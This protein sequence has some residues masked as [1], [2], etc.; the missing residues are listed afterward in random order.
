MVPERTADL[1]DIRDRV[2]A[3]LMGLP[4]PGLPELAEPAILLADDLA[5]VDAVELDPTQVQ[6]LVLAAGGRTGHTAIV[7]RQLN[8]PCV[9]GLGETL[10]AVRSGE[11]VLVDGANGTVATGVDPGVGR[12][13]VATAQQKSH[14][15]AHWQGPGRT[16]DGHRVRLLA[17]VAGLSAARQAANGVAEE[18]GLFRSELSFLRH[19]TEPG[20]A[21]QAGI[22]AELLESFPDRRVVIRTYDSGSDKPLAFAD[23][24]TAK[25]SALGIRGIRINRTHAGLVERQLDAI[26]LAATQLSERGIATRP[27]VMAPMV[28]AV[29][30]AAWFAAACRKRGLVPGAMIEV[31]AAALMADR[32]LPH[33]EFVSIGTNDLTQPSTRWPRTGYPPDSVT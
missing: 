23:P 29:S 31:P 12:A 6:A 15:A 21:E 20:V 22:Y 24:G 8:I 18:I 28:A 14:L 17:S 26:A 1:A 19:R 25:S 2:L 3:Q 9:V 11:L 33:L 30:E 16:R 27:W 10:A 13:A 7:A 4:A 32:I 5:P